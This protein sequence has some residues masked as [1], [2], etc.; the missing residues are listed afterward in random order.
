MDAPAIEGLRPKPN[1]DSK[2]YWDGLLEGRILLQQCADCGTFRH[3]PRPLCPD[4]YSMAVKWVEAQGSGTVH[5]W[6]VCHH[7]FHHA[8]KQDLPTV[9]VTVDL[10]EG[11]RLC[12]RLRKGGGGD[13]AVGRPVRLAVETVDQDLALPIVELA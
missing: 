4:C 3:Y 8:Y 11:V 10:P 1:R 12:G 13:M 9:Y 7:A 2:P 6:T 5:T